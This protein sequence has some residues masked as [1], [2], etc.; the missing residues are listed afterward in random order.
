MLTSVASFAVMSVEESVQ[1]YPHGPNGAGTEGLVPTTEKPGVKAVTEN[2][3]EGQP[4]E[5]SR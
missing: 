1:I 3:W 4:D 2:T 5:Q